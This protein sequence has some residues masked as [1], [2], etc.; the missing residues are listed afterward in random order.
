MSRRISGDFETVLIKYHCLNEIKAVSPFALLLI[1]FQNSILEHRLC[2][3][4]QAIKHV[5]NNIAYLNIINEENVLSKETIFH[6]P[7]ILIKIV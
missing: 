3:M 2:D 5:S 7:F 6:N 1:S 4:T